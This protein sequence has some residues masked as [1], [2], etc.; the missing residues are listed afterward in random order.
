M[1]TQHKCDLPILDRYEKDSENKV[2]TVNGI[3][4]LCCSKQENLLNA[5]T[6][7]KGISV[8]TCRVCQRNHYTLHVD[9]GHYTKQELLEG[10]RKLAGNDYGKYKKIFD[11]SQFNKDV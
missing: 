3:L 9:P 11:F 8:K 1:Q 6:D 5:Q 4:R 2:T 7:K 10:V